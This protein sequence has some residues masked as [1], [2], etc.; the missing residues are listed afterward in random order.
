MNLSF[1]GRGAVI[2]LLLLA[3]ATNCFGELPAKQLVQFF[4]IEPATWNERPKAIFGTPMESGEVSM[5]TRTGDVAYVSRKYIEAFFST[6]DDLSDV[7]W[8]VMIPAEFDVDSR[9]RLNLAKNAIRISQYILSGVEENIA[10][11]DILLSTGQF[12][13][14]CEDL[15]ETHV[16]GLSANMDV[17]DSTDRRNLQL[18]VRENGSSDYRRLTLETLRNFWSFSLLESYSA[19]R[20]IEMRH[21]LQT[22]VSS[23]SAFAP[24]NP[25]WY[26]TDDFLPKG[27]ILTRDNLHK[28]SIVVPGEPVVVE[29][30]KGS[31]VIELDGSVLDEAGI[32]DEIRVRLDI[33]GKRLAG[34]VSG[35]RRVYVELL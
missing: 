35:L 21:L 20:T 26:I 24:D 33:S 19:G 25:Y 29:I 8:H 11:I 28:K 14:L 12:H 17:E 9:E 6:Y 16:R 15:Q 22:V 30:K 27:T 3:A 7:A 23:T 13:I 5:Q 4:P 2:S 1:S 34:T 10:R 31:V 32:G 18:T